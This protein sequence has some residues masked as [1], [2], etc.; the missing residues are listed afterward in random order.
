[1]NRN[2]CLVAIPIILLSCSPETQSE[3][4]DRYKAECIELNNKLWRD[5]GSDPNTKENREFINSDCVNKA[6][7]R[8]QR[9]TQ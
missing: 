1:M 2:R 8:V 6:Y 4:Y 3:K 7:E 9:E 5:N